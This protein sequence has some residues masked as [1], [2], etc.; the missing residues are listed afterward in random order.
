[1]HNQRLIEVF[2]DFERTIIDFI[3]RNKVNAAEYQVAVETIIAS[4][5]HGEGSM[6]FD[7]FFEASA[8]DESSLPTGSP[9]SMA[10]PFHRPGAPQ[11]EPPCVL[12]QR[13]DEQG[14]P[15]LFGGEVISSD[16]VPLAGAQLDIWQADA[17]GDYSQFV[18]GIPEW[19]L[20][21]RLV[22]DEQGRFQVRTIQP[23]PYQIPTDGPT[24]AVLSALG[25]HA[26]RPAHLHVK[27]RAEGHHELTSQ[28]YFV[29]DPYLDDDTV[30]GV[31]DGLMLKIDDHGS[32]RT[33]HYRFV[34]V[35]LASA[36]RSVPSYQPSLA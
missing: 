11:L 30:G 16:G 18:P 27:V 14:D 32:V 7:T 2:T 13:P 36:D 25:R 4:I 35:P 33:A 3:R 10:G 5:E 22:T 12:P 19:N 15:L 1:M 20:R 24:G 23:P 21:G 28:L 29:G 17:A 6:I 8:T 26:W 31:R 9:Q 34:L